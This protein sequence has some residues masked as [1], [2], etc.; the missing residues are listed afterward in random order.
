MDR[1]PKGRNPRPMRPKPAFWLAVFQTALAV[2]WL[3]TGLLIDLGTTWF[4]IAMTL[5]LAANAIFS[6]ATYVRARRAH[7]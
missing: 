6:W 7:R 3:L 5:L 4:L 2:G 1:T